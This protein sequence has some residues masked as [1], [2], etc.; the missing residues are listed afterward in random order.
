MTIQPLVA[1]FRSP[2]QF[3]DLNDE[4]PGD[5]IRL[6]LLAPLVY[7]SALL[8]CT[9]RVPEK[10]VTDLGSVPRVLWNL[11]PPMGRADKGFVIHDWLYQQGTCTRGQADAVLE[12][13]MEVLQVRWSLR[14]AIYRGVRL[15]GFL[16]WRSYRQKA[17]VEVVAKTLAKLADPQGVVQ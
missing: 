8:Q 12:E 1:C 6:M 13:A 10:F 2:L 11:V 4:L 3:V 15:G 9:T 7:D 14:A 16:A 5:R 17:H